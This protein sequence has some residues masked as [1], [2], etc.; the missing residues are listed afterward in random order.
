[1]VGVARCG[2]I[3]ATDLPQ[4]GLTNENRDMGKRPGRV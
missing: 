4:P 3:T 2:Y 1:V